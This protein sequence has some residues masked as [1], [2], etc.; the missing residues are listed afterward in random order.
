M[1][2]PAAKEGCELVEVVVA[3]AVEVE[4]EVNGVGVEAKA[5]YAL[6]DDGW[7]EGPRDERASVP[8]CWLGRLGSLARGTSA[9]LGS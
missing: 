6:F 3:M 8:P 5:R 9:C 2:P 4:I 1:V 7:G